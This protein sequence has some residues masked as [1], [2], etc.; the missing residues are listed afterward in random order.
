M[1]FNKFKDKRKLGNPINS[2]KRKEYKIATRYYNGEK[3]SR[4]TKE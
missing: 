3:C 4:M 1:Y 2:H